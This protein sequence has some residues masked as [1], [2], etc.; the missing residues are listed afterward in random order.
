[1]A[2]VTSLLLIGQQPYTGGTNGITDF[3]TVLGFPL[4]ETRTQQGLYLVTALALCAAF[5]LCR[6][7]TRGRFGRV[8]A[9]IRD[10]ENRLRY[11]GYNPVPYKTLVFA[12]SAALAGLAGALFVPQVGIISPSNVGVVPSIEMAVWVAVG[13]RGTLTGAVV[14]ALVVNAAKSA[15]SESLPDAWLY[16][17]GSLFIAVVMFVPGGCVGLWRSV[18][19]AGGKIRYGFD[20]L[21]GRRK[22]VFRGFQG[23]EQPEL[24]HA[25]RG[26]AGGDRP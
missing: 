3:R 11:L 23:T 19:R 10:G 16:L 20:N 8:L 17:F 15:F 26:T 18:V 9:A 22:R 7:M 13:G 24:H 4:D 25:A 6:A 1:M 2:L 14:G 5:V 21:P 12:V